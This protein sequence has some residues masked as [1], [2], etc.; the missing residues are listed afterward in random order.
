[1]PEKTLEE[2]TWRQPVPR[3]SNVP[4]DAVPLMWE[5]VVYGDYWIT[6]RGEVFKKNGTQMPEKPHHTGYPRVS[7]VKN[8]KSTSI[9]VHNL[10]AYTFKPIPSKLIPAIDHVDVDKTNHDLHNL[11]FT[12][13]AE[14]T[15]RAY[16]EG[17]NK[18]SK[19]IACYDDDGNIVEAFY[20]LAA[21][22]EAMR[23]SGRKSRVSLRSVANGTTRRKKAFGYRWKYLD[24]EAY[25]NVKKH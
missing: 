2:L 8:G 25:E 4:R 17:A 19:P 3:P 15:R 21:A 23:Q 6:P 18:S 9:N 5:G 13:Q 1:M 20:S 24:W 12:G 16:Q 7:I 11:E 10:V 22:E 14:N